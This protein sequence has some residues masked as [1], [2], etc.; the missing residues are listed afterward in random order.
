M[1]ENKK[2]NKLPMPGKAKR[3]SVSMWWRSA[4]T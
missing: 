4:L 1:S 3:A 2:N